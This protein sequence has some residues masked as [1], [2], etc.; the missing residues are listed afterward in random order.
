VPV[1]N[2]P[3]FHAEARFQRAC[4]NCGATGAFHAH[5]VVDKQ[6]LRN[7]LR[8]GKKDNRLYD[9]RNA[10]RLCDGLD[11][12]RCHMNMEWGSGTLRVPTS[13]LTDDNVAYAFEVLGPWAADYLR[14]QYVDTPQDPR[15]LRLESE[16]ERTA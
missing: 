15:I 16:L 8:C 5:H 7:V 10:L 3:S 4:A 12:K 6:T 9:T 2:P 13:K 1:Q 11:G 14:K